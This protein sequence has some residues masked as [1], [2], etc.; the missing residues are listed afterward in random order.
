MTI[1]PFVFVLFGTMAACCLAADPLLAP[2]APKDQ[3][4]QQEST[5]QVDRAIAP[6]VAQAR[7]SYP[8]AKQRF[9]EGLPKGQHFF[10]TT[11]LKDRKD[12]VEQVFVAVQSIHDG[13]V[14]GKIWSDVMRAEGFRHG[15][16]YSFPESDMIDW[17]IT[18]PDGS[19]EGNFVGKFLDTYNSRKRD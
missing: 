11:R 18:K 12:N 4:F 16:A 2:N 7:A 14:R 13:Q 10:L 17:L 6:Y 3:P 19:E 8:Q 15:D 5:S 1:R 9:L